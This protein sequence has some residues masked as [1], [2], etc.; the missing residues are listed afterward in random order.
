MTNLSRT[1]YTGITNDLQRRVYEHKN[2]T[3]PVFTRRYNISKLV[4]YE[5]LPHAVS[6][7][8]REKEIKGWSRAKRIDL[9][10]SLNPS[11][12]DLASDWF[13]D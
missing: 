13:S 4:Y 10:N 7:I 3:L 5:E 11:W 2:K 8:A 6:A 1:L 12:E 9:I